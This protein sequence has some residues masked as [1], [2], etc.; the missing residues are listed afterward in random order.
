MATPKGRMI[1][2]D[3][4]TQRD[5][6]EPRGS[7]YLEGSGEILTNLARLTTFARDR[8]V[9]VLATACWHDPEE[10]NPE[11]EFPPTAWSTAR[12]PNGSTRPAG[13]AAS[14]CPPTASST[15]PGRG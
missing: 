2:V 14:C 15:R 7:V 4:D 9:P 10:P 6:L 11:P 8:D 5:F 12:G 1:F 3:I 13:P